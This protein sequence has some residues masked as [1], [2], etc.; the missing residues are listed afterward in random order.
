AEPLGL[1][2]L[3]QNGPEA[4]PVLHQENAIGVHRVRDSCA[5]RIST[6]ASSLLA[7]SSSASTPL[8]SSSNRLRRSFIAGVLVLAL[9][10]PIGG[11][12]SPGLTGV[13]SSDWPARGVAGFARASRLAESPSSRAWSLAMRCRPACT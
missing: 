13:R 4:L 11:G 9:F 5:K 3:P 2:C 8:I 6:E 1:Q 7:A 12:G 10:T